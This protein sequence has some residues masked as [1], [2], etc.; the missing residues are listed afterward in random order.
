M[1]ESVGAS[2]VVFNES[3]GEGE[4]IGDEDEGAVAECACSESVDD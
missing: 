3:L 1:A 4:V 2:K